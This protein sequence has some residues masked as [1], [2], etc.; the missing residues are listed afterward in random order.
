MEIRMEVPQRLKIEL[1]YDP[2]IPFLGIYPKQKNKTKQTN[3]QKNKKK[4]YKSA[5]DGD[6]C[7]FMSTA[8]LFSTGRDGTSPGGSSIGK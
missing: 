2:A 5:Y 1:P 4:T 6:V 8:A 3:K 7:T